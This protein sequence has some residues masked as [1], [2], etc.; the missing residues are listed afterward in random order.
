VLS[1]G[2]F[3]FLRRHSLKIVISAVFLICLAASGLVLWAGS[4][5]A[6]PTRRPVMDYHREFLS[7]PAA[8]GM[9]IERFTASDGTPTLLCSPE[10]SGTLGDRGLKIRA[11]LMARGLSLTPAGIVR[12]T[13][14]LCH[15]RKGRKEDYLPIAE[16]LCAAGFRCVIP[17]LPAHGDHPGEIA[18]YGVREAELPARILDEASRKFAFEK[19]PAGLLGMSMGGSIAVHSAQIPD[20]PWQA[21]VVISSFD[22][23]PAAIQGQASRYLGTTLGPL[24]ASGTAIA[25]HWRSG[26]HLADIQPGVHGPSIKIP[27]LIAHGTADRVVPMASGR[28]LFDSLAASTLKKWQEIPTAD[29]DNVLITSHPIYADIAEWMLQHVGPSSP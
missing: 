3:P 1:P 20:A 17:D 9:R 13:L 18:T 4:E 19:Q 12:G 8:H 15:G 28:R 25:Y 6:S 26:T 22:S 16:R 21:L 29:H 24:W 10:P 27:V 2:R 11:Q 14:V 23:F 7:N 5:I